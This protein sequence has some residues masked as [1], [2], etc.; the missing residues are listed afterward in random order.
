MSSKIVVLDNGTG[1]VKVGFAGQNFPA[2]TFPSSIGRP[3]LRASESAIDGRSKTKAIK[4]NYVGDEVTAQRALLDISHPIENGVVKDWDDMCKIWEYAFKEKLA[5]PSA[6]LPTSK[7][8]LTEA[9]MNPIKN[10]EK[11]IEIMFERF[12][13]G[14]AYIA[15]QAVLTLYAQGL[16]TGVVVD[17]GDGVSHV[18]PV[19]EGHELKHAVK[20]LDIAGRDVTRNLIRL[21]D[22]RGYAFNNQ[23]SDFESIRELKEKLCYAGYP[24]LY[25]PHF[26]H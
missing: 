8:L 1:Y 14:H 11:M 9:P 24:T 15:V 3:I 5:L 20:R 19:Y 21:L 23:T 25:H 12:G 16:Q 22:Q 4:E 13:F 6:S 2:S 18:V 10:R 7:I 26:M 17:C